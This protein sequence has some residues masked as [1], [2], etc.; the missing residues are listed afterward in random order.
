MD[1][2]RVI[3]LKATTHPTTG[4]RNVLGHSIGRWE[5]DT[6][7]VDTA[8]FAPG[9]ILQYGQD[10]ATGAVAGVLHS[11]AYRLTERLR[12]DSTTGSL[13]VSWTQSDPK[14]FTRSF[15]AP[16]RA[17]FRRPDLKIGRYNCQKD[18]GPL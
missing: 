6:L 16:P 3:D 15:D 10:Q 17:F 1:A 5:G 11:D 13:M 7:V 18:T 9:V 12:V 2:V 4:R 14:Y 8:F